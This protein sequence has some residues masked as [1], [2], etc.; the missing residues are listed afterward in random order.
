[1]VAGNLMHLRTD[2]KVDLKEVDFPT[3]G[4]EMLHLLHPTSAI[5]GLPKEPAAAFI[6]E[7][8]GYNR[9]YY[10]GYLGPVNSPVGTHLFVNLRCMQLLENQAILYAGAGITG[11]S[12]PEKEYQETQHKMQTMRSIL[13]KAQL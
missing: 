1:V 8:E 2:F 7:N 6:K 9:S 13:R 12:S 11:E 4:S 10:S 5:C 3:L